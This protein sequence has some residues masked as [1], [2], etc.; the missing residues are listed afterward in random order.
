MKVTSVFRVG[1][2]VLAIA[3]CENQVLGEAT[4]SFDGFHHADTSYP[5]AIKCNAVNYVFGVDRFAQDFASY[6]PLNVSLI[7]TEV[8]FLSNIREDLENDRV[9][10]DGGDGGDQHRNYTFLP[11]D[12]AALGTGTVDKIR[13][14]FEDA[15]DWADGFH[16]RALLVIECMK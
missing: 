13:G 16:T 5:S 12:L 9:T 14:L 1:L 10:I 3:A 8:D 2:A 4:S 6:N 15:Y 7:T 11:A